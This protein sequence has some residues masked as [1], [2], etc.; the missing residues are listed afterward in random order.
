M[1]DAS[2][3]VVED[4][5]LVAKEIRARLEKMEY[6]VSA[7]AYS[8]EQAISMAEETRPDIILMD[9]KLKGSIDGIEAAQ[10]IN[11]RFDIPVVYLTAYSDETTL[12]RAKQ[13][14]PYGYITKPFTESNLRTNIAVAL[15]KHGMHIKLKEKE[16]TLSSM[17]KN[18]RMA[19]ITTNTQGN[20]ITMNQLAEEL[21]GYT[22]DDVLEKPLY[23]IFQ[24]K[25]YDTNEYVNDLVEQVLHQGIVI[26][27]TNHILVDKNGSNT[28]IEYSAAPIEDNEGNNV[29]IVLVI[30]DISDLI[31]MQQELHKQQDHLRHQREVETSQ[32]M[33]FTKTLSHELKTP[34]TPILISTGLLASELKEEPLLS[35]AK[36][37]TRSASHL[38][39]TIDQ[40]L[41]IA[42]CEAGVLQLNIETIDLLQIIRESIKEISAKTLLREGRSLQLMLPPALPSVQADRKRL[43]QIIWNLIENALKI[44]PEGGTVRIKV[45][46][47]DS[48]AIV[49]VQDTGRGFT[50]Q[51]QQQLFDHYQFVGRNTDN[52]RELGPRF[53]YCKNLVK[54]HSGRVWVKSSPSK[55]STFGFSLPLDEVNL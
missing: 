50:K 34:L 48:H 35:L 38:R 43:N 54:L 21:S 1:P 55:G 53:A 49:E 29:G 39:N 42:K 9:I 13:T 33:E 8:G 51:E 2:V 14:S 41:D 31:L 17:L 47:L 6:R 23:E 27:G 20:T 46:Q 52:Y 26:S 24:I 28:P 44:T 5:A 22:K 12:Q 15:H 37:A 10:E 11:S 30:K 16:W 18:M 25:D 3:M 45:C 36:N 40:L 32:I 4:Q 7:V 19:V